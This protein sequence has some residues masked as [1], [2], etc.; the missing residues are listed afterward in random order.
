ML[1][2]FFAGNTATG[3]DKKIPDY[4][5]T[6]RSAVPVEFTWKIE[7]IYPNADV[8]KSD[9]EKVKKMSAQIE[10]LS[11]EWTIDAKKMLQMYNLIN[12]ISLLGEKL[13]S[14][15]S[16]QSNSDLGNTQFIAMKGEIENFFVSFGAMLSFIESDLLSLGEVRFAE[17]LKQE[18]G[19]QP[20]R[21]GTEKTFRSKNHILPSDQQK[22]VSLTGLFSGAAEQTYGVFSNVEMPHPEITLGDGKKINLNVA[23][24]MKFRGDKNPETRALVMNSFWNNQKQFE[25]TFASMLNGEIK[26]HWF[27]AQV[28]K[29]NSC[30]EARLHPTAIDEKVYSQLI[31]AVHNHLAS[32]HRFLNLK[33]KM[34]GLKNYSYN[35]IYASAVKSVTKIYTYDEARKIIYNAL[36]PLGKEYTDIVDKAFADRWIDMYPNKGKESGAYSSGLYGVHPYIKMNYNGDYNALSTLAHELGHS[37]HSFYADKTQHYATSQYETFIAEIA[38]TFNE[39]LLMKYILKTENDDLFKIFIL[40]QYLDNARATIFR[41]TLFAEFELAMHQRVESGQ[42]LTAEWLN[43]TY[44][45]L[46]RLYYGHDKSVMDVP[47]YIQSEWSYIPHFYMNYYVFQYSTGLIASMA[48]SEMVMNGKDAERNK[49]IELLSSGGN[50]YPLNLLKKAGVDMTKPEAY[51]AA[52]SNFDK[53]VTE[54]EALY[55]KL[56]KEGRFN[57]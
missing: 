44:L 52:F 12:D 4:S 26:Q 33:K 9:L 29:Y 48:L 36:Q 49:Y 32:L 10:P 16:H 3:Q 5:N 15:A 46:T 21:F 31:E 8:W 50:D 17:Y 37:L 25:N 42:S 39:N 18:P 38:S 43:K 47:E 53:M 19:L 57:K 34:L 1:A 56:E 13:Y 28:R 41:Q 45:D 35:D 30:L 14:Y 11:K 22:I 51:N 24:Y 7:D 55:N 2:L 54:M 27:S 20:Y 23:G 40:D 6:E